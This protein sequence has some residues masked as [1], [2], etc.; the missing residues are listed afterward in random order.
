MAKTLKHW[1]DWCDAAGAKVTDETI[2]VDDLMRHFIRPV[3]LTERPNLV[4]LAAEWPWEVFANVREEFKIEHDGQAWPLV[5]ADLEIRSHTDT[6]PIEIR[7]ATPD[8]QLDYDV[9]IEEGAMRFAAVGADATV[10]GSRILSTFQEYLSKNGLQIF[11]EKEALVTPD[12]IL[13]QPDRTLPPYDPNDLIDLDWA[14]I[15]LSVESQ[16]GQRRADSIQ[17]Y[18][19]ERVKELAAWDVVLDDDISNE[20]ADIVALRVSGTDLVVHLTHCKYVS[21][22]RPCEPRQ[23]ID[24][25]YDVCGQAMKSVRW[26]RAIDTF[27]G[28]L[29]R[30]QRQ[31]VERNGVSGFMVGDELKLLELQDQS[32]LLKPQF[33]IAIA[34]PGLQKHHHSPAQLELL[35]ATQTYVLDVANGAFEV[36]CSH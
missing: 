20:M 24:D 9:T 27:F 8:W 30:R 26:R 35:A 11:F 1:V 7:V 36:Y 13:L 18:M 29:I 4:P 34:Q 16:G 12:A 6:G 10:M 17:A 14:G 32:R 33:T 2:S 23:R 15:N 3:V 19:I 22:W 21:G 28:N 31:Y 5:D 25:L